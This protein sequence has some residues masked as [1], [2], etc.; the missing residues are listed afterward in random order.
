MVATVHMVGDPENESERMAIDYLRH[1]L[2]DGYK[3]YTNLEIRQGRDKKVYEIDLILLAPHCIYVVDFKG[4]RGRVS[5]TD[6]QWYPDNREPYPSPIKKMGKHAK[7][8]NSAICDINRANPSLKNIYVMGAVLMTAD[9]VEIIDN[10]HIQVSD[11][12]TYLDKRCLSF[13]QSLD[14]L[15]HWASTDIRPYHAICERGIV[16]DRY[17][18]GV[19]TKRSRPKCYGTWLIGDRLGED[20]RKNYIEYSAKHQMLGVGGWTARLRVYEIDPLLPPSE[21]ESQQKILS[22]AFQAIFQIPEHKNILKVKDCFPTESGDALIYI[23]EEIKGKALRQCMADLSLEQRLEVIKHVLYALDHVHKHGVIHRNINPDSILITPQ[24][25]AC[26]TGFD[27]ARISDRTT[28]IAEDIEEELEEYVVYQAIE[29]QHNPAAAS[30]TSDLFSAGLVFYELL[31]GASAFESAEQM[32]ECDAIFPLKPSARN[33]NLPIEID[34]WLQKLC[35]CNPTERFSSA[36]DAFQSLSEYLNVLL[37]PDITNLPPEYTID[38]QFQVIERLGQ[39]GFAVAYKVFNIIQK[40]EQVL[41]LVT[42]DRYSVFDRLQQEYLILQKIPKHPH[43]VDVIW[44]GLLGNKTPFIV[45]EYVEGKDVKYLIESKSLS[46][47]QSIQIARETAIGIAHLHKYKVRHQDI[48]PSNLLLTESGVRIIDFNVA[49]SD[50]D[51]MTV[52][53]GTRPYIPPDC[54]PKFNLSTD[55]KI[56]RD[57]YA[58]GIVFYECIT[59]RYPFHEAQPPVAKSP[60]DPRQIEGCE[61]LSEDLVEILMKAIAPKRADRF[62]TAQEFLESL[63]LLFSSG[64]P[65]ESTLEPSFRKQP[66]S[67]SPDTAEILAP[68][69]QLIVEPIVQTPTPDYNGDVN[70]NF[71]ID[72]LVIDSPPNPDKP[73]VL[74]RSGVY[75]VPSSYVPIRTEVEWL[76]YFGKSN[77]PYWV[78]GDRLCEWALKWLEAWGK[79]DMV[80]IKQSPRR[81]LESLFHPFPLP[82]NWTDQQLLALELKLSSFPQNNPIAYLLAEVTKSDPQTWLEGASAYNLALWLALQVPSEYR[83]FE[84]VWQHR[85]A[86]Q[87]EDF[88]DYY[89]TPDKLNL[90]SQWVNIAKPPLSDLGQYPLPIPDAIALKFE[91]FWEQEIRR[92]NGSILDSQSPKQVG[93]ANISNAAYKVMSDRPKLISKARVAKLS[94][95]AARRNNLLSQISPEFPIPLEIDADVQ[96]ACDWAVNSYLP[97]R[98]W[99]TV[100]QKLPIAQRQSDVLAT[101]FEDWIFKHYPALKVVPV[102]NSALNY[103]VAAMVRNLY[104]NNPVLW[105]VVD[106]LGWLDHVELLQYLTETKELAIE[107]GLSPRLSMLP[108]K[109]EYAKWSLYAQLPSNDS[110]WNPNLDKVFPKMGAGERYTDGKRETRLY[111]DL[112]KG[113]RQLYCWDTEQLDELYHSGRNWESLYEVE[114]PGIL[115]TLAEQIKYCIRLHPNPDLVKL[116]IASDHGQ[117]MGEISQLEECPE[118][119]IAKGRMAIG[120]TDDPRFIVLDKDHFGLPHDISVVKGAFCLGAFNNT[121]DGNALGSHGGLFPEEVLVGV[122]VLSRVAT[123]EPVIIVCSGSG[124]A[125]QAGEIEI[126][127]DNSMNSVS[128]TSLCLFVR[129]ISSLQQGYSDLRSVPARERV[130]YKIQIPNSPELPLDSDRETL[131]LTGEL[132]FYFADIEAGSFALDSNSLITIHQ[133]FSSGFKSDVFSDW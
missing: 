93:L 132:N 106:G 35:A 64:S 2:P 57:L 119:L 13:F 94:L 17:N 27:Y 52:S 112:K 103:S 69:S 124:K 87:S 50:D 36:D 67:S 44:S 54:K 56:D 46:L 47:E 28:T 109:T 130:T 33:S 125:G 131:R 75:P 118:G 129:E 68:E 79:T 89:C 95:S 117:M 21:R 80:E 32:Q 65:I 73:I 18:K 99:E 4:V 23:T 22:N 39:G 78:V 82:D 98:K 61:D 74:D 19:A 7:I 29:C 108:T 62:S 11:W 66:E 114:R 1:H 105:V 107:V 100:I 41:K 20:A 59:G 5:V 111:P 31:T 115:R 128:L 63:D 104:Q 60:I 97:F 70:R 45:F 40:T 55:E 30:I 49:I 48:K 85:Q 16:G 26:L 12:I 127:I 42:R 110:D 10:S 90:L 76:Q 86:N 126:T 51:Q 83:P 113:D 9:D 120:R 25:S 91:Q 92:T 14:F 96:S 38:N 121:I 53:A 34:R 88:H 6:T 102:A 133:M 77:S 101:S 71:D 15:P 37:A 24:G 8:L 81:A 123:R 58:L 116:V 3:L 43:I 122:S 72:L 84:Q